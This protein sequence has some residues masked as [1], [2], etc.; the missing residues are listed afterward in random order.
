MVFKQTEEMLKEKANSQPNF[1]Q[2][3]E[4]ISSSLSV[5]GEVDDIFRYGLVCKL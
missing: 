2:F 1:Q 3:W 4:K 5:C